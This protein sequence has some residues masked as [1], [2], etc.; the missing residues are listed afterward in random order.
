SVLHLPTPEPLKAIYMTQCVVGTKDF[1]E[2]LVALVN[3]TELNSV[4]IDIKDFSGTIS[5]MPEDP[6]FKKFAITKCGAWDMKEFVKRLHE[7]GIYVIGRITVFQDPSMVLAHPELA[8]KKKSDGSVWKDYKGLSFID[9]GATPH[10]DYIADLS[11]ESYNIGF[12][13]INFDY[14]RFPSDGNM[15]D[16]DYTLSRG[17]TKAE[18]LREFF[19]YLHNKLKDTGVKTSVD[20][21]GMVTT[22]NDDLN[23]GQLLE[24][25]LP[26]FDYVS[27]MVYPS[28][29]PPNFN[30]WKNPNLYPG[31]VVKF[32]MDRAVIRT[33]ATTTTIKLFGSGAMASTGSTSS[34]QASPQLYTKDAYSK[35]KLRPW[36]Q[37]FQY[38]GTY[39][40]KEVRAQIQATYDAGLT[41]WM[42]WSPSNKYTEAALDK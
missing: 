14:V 13:E 36:L 24:N 3:R 16:I 28:H 22:N 18:S 11:K 39:G 21:F 37:D 26:Y 19:E 35:L 34:P 25:A 1:R 23:I 40:P 31:E 7:Q 2:R 42:L 12:D 10:W 38:G 5:F 20:L 33:I 15:K 30:G 6:K 17:K 27:P 9:V 32:S 4:L 8:V 41:S 29:Y